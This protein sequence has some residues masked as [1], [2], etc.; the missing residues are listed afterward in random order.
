MCLCLTPASLRIISYPAGMVGAV[1]S[2]KMATVYCEE[3]V[4]EELVET[5]FQSEAS[6]L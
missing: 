5:E 1:M 4:E 6:P 2:G 3:T